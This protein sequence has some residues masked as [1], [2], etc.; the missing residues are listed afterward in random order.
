[1]GLES[2]PPTYISQLNSSNPTT[3]DDVAEG[4]DHLRMIKAVLK[5]QFSGLSGTTA[6][7]ASEA[8]LNLMDGVTA[9]TAEL[10]ILDGVTSTYA[11]LNILDGVTSTPA[12]LNTLDVTTQGTSEASKVL[13][14]DSNGDV[15][16]ADGAYD[17]D[18][19][20]H[21]GTN[22]LLLGGTLVTASATEVNLLD[23]KSVVGDAVL[24]TDQSW[25]G[26][27]RATYVTDNDGSYDL[28]AGQNFVTTPSGT[29]TIT[30]TT[31]GS[32][33]SS[34]SSNGQSGF[35][36]LINSGGETISLATNSKGADGM[37]TTLT[38]AGTYLLSYFS[39]GTDV[40][41]TNSAI[42]A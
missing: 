2:G 10:N 35:I 21:D 20:S 22:G 23:G 7:S 33:M 38:V 16:I 28:D 19:A 37:G 13:T 42:Y 3:S 26:S 1:M 40:W 31:G 6:I 12:E 24:A 25:T 41:L 36:K 32:D 18:V 5:N 8:E 4:D 29:T 27:Q 9:T 34:A 15:T 11:E 14:A 39:D 30:F 17:F